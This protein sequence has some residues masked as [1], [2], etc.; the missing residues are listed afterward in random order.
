ML[1]SV[2][3]HM[4]TAVPRLNRISGSALSER[5]YSDIAHRVFTSPRR[6]RFKE[7]EYAVPRKVGLEALREVRR[8]IDASRWRIGFPVEIRTAPADDI[9]LSTASGRDSMYLAFHVPAKADHTE[10]FAG[11]EKVL[12]SFDGRPHWGKMH[13]LEADDLA[14]LYPGFE[15]FL[16]LRDE[17]DPERVFANPYLRRM[18]GD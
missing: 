17:L 10:Y 4:P 11:V 5:T 3:T 6:V 15:E 18:L 12:R 7:M 1:T 2:G 16:I 13:S 14:K 9:T 8:V